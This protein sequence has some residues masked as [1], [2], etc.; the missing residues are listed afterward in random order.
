M[1][2]AAVRYLAWFAGGFCGAAFLS[3]CAP[4]AARWV[5]A[6]LALAAVSAALFP[7]TRRALGR[8]ALLS[9]GLL[10]GLGWCRLSWERNIRPLEALDGTVRRVDAEAR[11]A[12]RRTAYGSRAEVRLTL[13][14]RTYRAVLYLDGDVS[15]HPGDRVRGTARLRRTGEKPGDDALYYGA[16]GCD[17]T[18]SLA[19]EPAIE[20]AGRLPPR[21]WPAALSEALGER[22][23]RLLPGAPGGFETALLTGAREGLPDRFYD[24]MALAGTRH[25]VA[26]SG[27]HAGILAG[28]LLLLLGS[29]RLTVFVSL[30]L[31]LF[32][33]LCAGM[34]A[35]VVRAV[36]ML[37]LAM[38]APLF[39]R[40][41]D[42]PTS[43]LVALTLILLPNPRAV[44]DV[45]LQLSFAS[46]AGI[47]LFSG[48]LYRRIWES[49]PG[50]ALARAPRAGSG[51]ARAA[52]SSVAASLGAVPLTLPLQLYYFQIFSL[53][54]PLSAALL[55]PPLPLLF[56]LGAAAALLSLL[57]YPLGALL[58]CPL[59]LLVR[60]YMALTSGLAA[61][62]FAAVSS[63]GPYLAIFLLG[64]YA[65]AV[66]LALE[67]RPCRLWVPC[68]ALALLF[69]ECLLFGAMESDRAGLSVSVLDVGQGQCVC[70]QSGGRAALYDC[71]GDGDPAERA[72]QFLQSAG[73]RS[74]DFLVL[75]HYDGDHAGGVA[76]LLGRVRV[77]TLYL[78]AAPDEAGVQAGILAEAE[79]RGCAVRF[80]TGDLTLSFGKAAAELYAP[81]IPGEGNE[82]CV[83]ARFS[84]GDF[85]IL[86]TGDLGARAEKK[87]IYEHGLRD[88]AAIVA[89]HH[90]SAGSTGP[91]ALHYLRPRLALISA[92]EGNGY[93][94]PAARTLARL[95]AAGALVYRPG[96]CGTIP[97]RW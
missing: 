28:A 65:A 12:S 48:R 64:F 51:A 8:L 92:G 72:A 66:Y 57:W 62:P 27:M 7:G 82:A 4:A 52:L 53:A 91:A 45:G 55:A 71:G 50:R 17:L 30:P 5:L 39:G 59:G 42:P 32:F 13:D 76:R 87:L 11:T 73:R 97:V 78:P 41:N 89:G 49:R 93:G 69:C 95:G 23:S 94:H 77:G 34:T 21:L 79:A 9:L 58:A 88:A 43:L 6:A 15:L 29:R 26:V 33:A 54:S 36:I 2:G 85:D 44:L 14:G 96:Q 60:V 47:Q 83:A 19:G 81:P 67:R 1:G 38:L 68:G 25:I 80:V 90:G 61:L 46:V 31:L 84:S 63:D 75:S 56:I 16:R 22:L 37:S 40:E 70:L 10:L 86:L 18:L 35:S 20:R 74:V 3:A 24:D